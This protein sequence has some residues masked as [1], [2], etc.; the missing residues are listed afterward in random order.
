M[1]E[2]LDAVSH[3]AVLVAIAIIGYLGTWFS[4]YINAKKEQISTQVSNDNLMLYVNL[5]SE[6]AIQ[7]VETLNSTLVD[8]LKKHSSDGKLTAEEIKLIRDTARDK[9]KKTL[10]AEVKESLTRV[11]G[12]LDEYF[13]TLIETTVVRVKQELKK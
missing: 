8:E 7:V 2:I 11:F 1:Q 10:S 13:D 5:V 9:L 12:D 3:A 6:N 4:K